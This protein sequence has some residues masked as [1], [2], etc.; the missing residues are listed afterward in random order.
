MYL[1]IWCRIIKKIFR[2]LQIP[3]SGFRV[4]K[5]ALHRPPYGLEY[6]GRNDVM[7]MRPF[8]AWQS[9]QSI[10]L[11]LSIDAVNVSH[12][13]SASNFQFSLFSFCYVRSVLVICM[14][15]LVKIFKQNG[16]VQSIDQARSV[17]M[18]AVRIHSKSIHRFL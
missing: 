10:S 9:Q 18:P 14:V 7:D 17:H 3:I 12:G 11:C 5:I 1:R 4:L 13:G 6:E 2:I 16:F 15:K 8:C